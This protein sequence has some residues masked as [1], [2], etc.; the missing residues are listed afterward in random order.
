MTRHPQWEARLAAFIAEN[1]ERAHAYGSFDCLVGLSA[2]GVE[3]VTGE[4]YAKGHRG[5]YKSAASAT[6]YLV[7]LGFDSPA[8]FL[9]SL[10][11]EKPIGFAKR[12]DLVLCDLSAFE[13]PQ[14]LYPG[15]VP[16]VCLGDFAVCLAADDER[17]GMVR[18]PRDLWLK[19]WAVGEDEYR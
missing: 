2:G 12:G 16:G 9:D 5:K 17:E 7:T 4:D 13:G 6:R 1:R 8:A 3:A 18:V 19:A 14:P 11:E 10:F 15:P